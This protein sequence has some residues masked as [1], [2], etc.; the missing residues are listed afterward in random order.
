MVRQSWSIADAVFSMDGDTIDFRVV[1]L[2]RK[3]Q[4][5]LMIDEAHSVGVLGKLVGG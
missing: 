4:A 2:C 1:E 3:Y 5:W